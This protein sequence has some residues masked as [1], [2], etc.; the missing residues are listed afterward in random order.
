MRLGVLSDTFS[1]REARRE[2]ALV[3]AGVP[4]PS[5]LSKVGKPRRRASSQGRSRTTEQRC[6]EHLKREPE[7]APQLS[8]RTLAERFLREYVDVY[9]KPTT[10]ARYREMLNR[11]ILPRLGDRP[12][13]SI[14][15][16]DAKALHGELSA[17]RGTADYAVCVLGSLYTR[18]IDDWE[19]SE[20]R[21]P[22]AG[23]KRFGSRRVERFLSPEERRRVE[24][25]ISRGLRL[26][27]G[28]RGRIAPYSAW[29]IRLLMLT[30]LRK[31]EILGLE[32]SMVDWQHSCF[33][34]PE[35]KRGQRTVL[36][37]DEVIEL[38]REIRTACSHPQTGL[39]LRGRNGTKL[40]CL[41]YTWNSI[42]Q[43]AGIPDVRIHDLRHSFASDA[44]MA[45]VPLAIVGEMLGHRNPSTT[46]RYAH[47][48]DSV[49]REALVTATR[50]IVGTVEEK[51][52]PF[53]RLDD[54][55]WAQVAPLVDANRPRP[56]PPVDLRG[57]VDAIRWVESQESARWSD[58]PAELGRPTTCWRWHKRWQ[59]RGVWAKVVAV[60]G[61]S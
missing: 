42:R 13:E 34:L 46:Q 58:L 5:T 28:N 57:V 32:W 2:A 17:S 59:K 31:S 18:I 10:R 53:M 35:T 30:G 22:C 26:R 8:V 12:F 20:M 14:C 41:N 3:L 37:S 48:A 45:G 40:T 24:A 44:L 7:P 55:Q 25:V 11:L 50:R 54:R 52:R 4:V 60:L 43:A 39:V 61:P 36:V 27:P 29:A 49:V 56:G 47:L 6:V 51:P 1:L 33:H 19:L 38:L 15:R 16:S 21:H 23:V 9:L